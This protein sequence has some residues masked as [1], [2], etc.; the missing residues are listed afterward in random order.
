VKY[1]IAKNNVSSKEIRARMEYIYD[2]FHIYTL[3]D[4]IN[5]T[6][7][8]IVLKTIPESAIDL[9]MIV[10]HDR[11]TDEYIR[12]NYKKIKES[13]IVVIACNTSK[14]SSLKL[15]K[16][17]N[18]F[19]PKNGGIIDFYD[20]TNYGFDFNTTDEEIMLYRNKNRNLYKMLND[21]FERRI[22]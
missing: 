21:T 20:G 14:F 11:R 3:K 2:L 7:D 16:N 22:I 17:K 15:L 18:I 5:S 6:K 4:N 13:N 1:I 12:D 19:L 8:I 9:Y 10:G